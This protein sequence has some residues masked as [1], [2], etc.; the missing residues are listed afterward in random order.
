M[1]LHRAPRDTG[2]CYIDR[3]NTDMSQRLWAS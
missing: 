3:R 1:S 2:V